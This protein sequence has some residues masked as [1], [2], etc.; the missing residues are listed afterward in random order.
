MTLARLPVSG[1]A[2][3]QLTVMSERLGAVVPAD[4]FAGQDAVT[5]TELTDLPYVA[6]PDI[7]PA[8]FDQLDRQLSEL[9]IKKRIKLTNTGFGGAAEV[10]SSGLAFSISMLD[11]K[12]PMHGY[13]VENVT[14]LPFVDFQPRLE[15]A[16]LWNSDRANGGDLDELVAEAREIFSEP[17]QI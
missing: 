5:L 3:E 8:Y 17:I 7:T 4:R 1:P 6:S 9:G 13:A 10:I 16:L 2:L 15:T 12:S 14:V 11:T